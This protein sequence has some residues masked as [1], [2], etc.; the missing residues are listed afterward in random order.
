M[1]LTG[2]RDLSAIDR[3]DVLFSQTF[4]ANPGICAFQGYQEGRMYPGLSLYYS[5]V[6]TGKWALVIIGV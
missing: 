2:D 4:F 6:S 1:L 3:I 5:N